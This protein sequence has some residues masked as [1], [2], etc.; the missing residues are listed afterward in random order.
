[1]DPNNIVVTDNVFYLE[2]ALDSD[3]QF[4]ISL[5][6][7]AELKN[8]SEIV[9]VPLRLESDNSNKFRIG[10]NV[11]SLLSGSYLLS[12]KANLLFADRPAGNRILFQ[13][14]KRLLLTD[15]TNKVV[16]SV[17]DLPLK[18]LH[19]KDILSDDEESLS[20]Q[21]IIIIGASIVALF[22]LVVLIVYSKRD[23]EIF[24]KFGMTKKKDSNLPVSSLESAKNQEYKNIGK[25][26][27]RKQ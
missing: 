25:E 22:F 20:I 16:M 4:N 8:Y 15:S 11:T 10:L 14:T 24:K 18:I 9:Q 12:F 5:P 2:L 19:E 27:P 23:K 26:S 3:T 17:T 1:M 13:H 6:E 7:K 21:L